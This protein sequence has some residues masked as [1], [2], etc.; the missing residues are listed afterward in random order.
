MLSGTR[1]NKLNIKKSIKLSLAINDMNQRD[2][3][4]K[5]GMSEGAISRLTRGNNGVTQ[6]SLMKI[7]KAFDIPVSEFVALG[8]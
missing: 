2:L 7:A 3:A 4:E 5:T 1:G 8:E 6:Y